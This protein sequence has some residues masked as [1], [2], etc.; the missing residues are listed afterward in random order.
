MVTLLGAKI[1]KPAPENL[2][3][4]AGRPFLEPEPYTQCH[5]APEKSRQKI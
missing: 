4:P 5:G 2:N 3:L 1:P